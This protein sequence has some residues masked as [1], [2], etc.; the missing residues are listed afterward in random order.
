MATPSGW[1]WTVSPANG[2]PSVRRTF[3]TSVPICRVR[4]GSSVELKTNVRP[5]TTRMVIGSGEVRD[6]SSGMKV[7]TYT[8]AG[9][10]MD[11][12]A[13]VASSAPIRTDPPARAV[14]TC[15]SLVRIAVPVMRLVSPLTAR[16]SRAWTMPPA[17]STLKST[18]SVSGVRASSSVAK[19]TR[20]A[21]SGI[22]FAPGEAMAAT[23]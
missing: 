2:V 18:V 19:L 12:F 1:A 7:R 6:P 13:P 17:A 10:A 16:S 5:S 14:M 15:P 11:T 8:P 22:Q 21:R 20:P 23:V 3:P 9:A 4:G